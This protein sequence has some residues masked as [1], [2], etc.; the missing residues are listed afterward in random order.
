MELP[1]AFTSFWTAGVRPGAFTRVAVPRDTQCFLTNACLRQDAPPPD[2]GCLTLWLRVNQN[3]EIAIVSFVTGRY[4]STHLDLRFAEG[5]T[6][7]LRISGLDHP[8]HICGYLTGGFEIEKSE[9][10]F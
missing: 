2:A 8:V 1:D 4:E 10:D 3:A 6:L 9:E 5:D 7:R